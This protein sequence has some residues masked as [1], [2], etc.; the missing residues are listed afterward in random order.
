MIRQGTPFS[1]ATRGVTLGPVARATRGLLLPRRIPITPDCISITLDPPSAVELIFEV[2]LPGVWI[3]QDV[4]SLEFI[5]VGVALEFDP[6]PEVLLEFE[7]EEEL[8]VATENDF[9]VVLDKAIEP[10]LEFSLA[11]AGI[12]FDAPEI[13]LEYLPNQVSVEI[14]SAQLEI[15]VLEDSTEVDPHDIQTCR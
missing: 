1:R 5:P 8:I 2:S 9:E 14:E 4:M 15:E 12:E 6:A 10:A 13:E 11:E 3:E 7:E